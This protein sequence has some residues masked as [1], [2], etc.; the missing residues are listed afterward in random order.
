VVGSAASGT[1]VWYRNL[2]AGRFAPAKP[3][4]MPALPYSP[5]VSV[6]DWNQDGDADLIVGTAYG[7]FCWLERSF[8]ERGYAKAERT[9]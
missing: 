4:D 2:G 7:Y 9:K 1:V 6:V 8:L 3:I 5:M